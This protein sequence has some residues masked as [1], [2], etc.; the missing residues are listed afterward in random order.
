V[1]KSVRTQVRP[2]GFPG[3]SVDCSGPVGPIPRSGRASHGEAKPHKTGAF[4]ARHYQFACQR[5]GLRA[6]DAPSAARAAKATRCEIQRP[7]GVA[8]EYPEPAAS[9]R[10][11][12]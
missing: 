12:K 7:R 11:M 9:S 10:V 4:H 8:T 1:R 2:G 6:P 3:D 5:G